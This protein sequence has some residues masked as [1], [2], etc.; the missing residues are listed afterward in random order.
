MKDF[1]KYI[2]PFQHDVLMEKCS[3][4]KHVALDMDGTIYMG[5]T[6]FDFTIP[7]LNTLTANGIGYSF[8][9]NNP[10]K[11]QEDYLKKLEKLG[12]HATKDEMYTTAIA[13]IDYIKVHFPDARRLFIL[14]TPSMIAEFER[15]GFVSV[16]DDPTERPDV[17][18][19]AFDMTL[20]Y[21]RLCRAAWWA[22]QG[23]PYIAT[24]PDKVCP[25][26]QEVV[27]VDCG[28][29]CR[30]IEYATDRR[31]DIVIGKPNPDM[32]DGIKNRYGLDASEIAMCGDRIY[33]DVAM[34]HNAGALGVLVLSGETT[35]ETALSSDPQPDITALNI[36]EFAELLLESKKQ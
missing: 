7:F 24:N 30:C 19:V 36:A 2:S 9:T 35:L 29:I 31:P 18:V 14:G 4:I 22:K 33:T 34:A 17:L 16:A 10:T 15:A 1:D 11:S 26:D 13:T 6:L 8:L 32:L 20:Q 23:V 28:S 12:I 27:L 25:T 3:K 5:S 21:S